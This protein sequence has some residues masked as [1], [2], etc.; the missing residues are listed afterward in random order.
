MRTSNASKDLE[1]IY[2]CGIERQYDKLFVISSVTIKGNL[3][4][5]SHLPRADLVSCE[6]TKYDALNEHIIFSPKRATCVRCRGFG[7]PPPE[8]A[9]YNHR[10]EEVI[11]S[12]SGSVTKYIN[13]A[14]AGVPEATY[15]WI[16]PAKLLFQNSREYYTCRATNDR[17][18]S[19]VRFRIWID[20]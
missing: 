1:G 18:S 12:R 17:A 14:D 19:N 9:I 13:V 16:N 11:I 2:Q 7:Y 20:S 3:S 10:D 6:N 15:T 8:V 5:F 4:P